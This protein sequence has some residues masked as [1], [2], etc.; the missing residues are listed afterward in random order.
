MP[1][2]M[3]LLVVFVAVALA[4][5]C[6]SVDAAPPTQAPK[7]AACAYPAPPAAHGAIYTDLV[8]APAG[9]WVT[10]YGAGFGGGGEVTLGGTPQT[11]ITHG[12]ACVIFQVSGPGGALAVGGK[13]AGNVAVHAGRVLEAK[14][15]NLRGVWGGAK[16]GD[17]IYLRAGNYQSNYGEGD[18]YQDATLETYKHGKPGQPIALV[19]YPGEMPVIMQTPGAT[20][21]VIALGDGN[22]RQRRAAHL[23]FANFSI[24]GRGDCIFG[25]G[26]TTDGYGGPDETGGTNVRVVNLNCRITDAESNTMTGMIATQG[27][28]WQIIGNTF[29]D[30]PNRAVIKNNHAI[31]IQGGADNVEVAYN[32]L[33]NLHMG[34][35]IQIHQDGKAKL[36]E[37]IHIHDNHLEAKNNTDMRGI[38]VVEVDDASSVIIERN[39]LKNLGADFSGIAVYRG[40][41]LVL[42]NQFFGIRAQ[43]L[44]ANGQRG[45]KLSIVASGNRFETVSGYP[46]VGAENGASMDDVKLTGN[47]YCSVKAQESGAKPCQ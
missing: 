38:S 12:P 45:G 6:E 47:R 29:I 42:D 44:S 20:H 28:G 4:T 27:D 5:A 11:V 3:K 21:S 37:N 10:V 7:P 13:A 46:A 2:R 31:Y 32:Q 22:A 43:A 16:P 8:T 39:V 17:V 35:V 34:H 9:A 23:V 30:P 33:V 15:S 36:Y 18:W 19:G 40:K 41:V 26:D 14:P 25:G 1:S 24:L